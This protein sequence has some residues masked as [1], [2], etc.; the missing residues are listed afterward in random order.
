MNENTNTTVDN[1]N[2]TP[3]AEENKTFSQSDIN[4]IVQERLAKEKS[5][6]DAV[7]VEREREL[8]Q[9]E[10][11][12]STREKLSSK[13]LPVELLDALNLS[14]AESAERSLSIL[15]TY[16]KKQSPLVSISPQNPFLGAPNPAPSSGTSGGIRQAMGLK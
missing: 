12:L 16:I 15:E 8:A 2:A 13:G 7:L 3:R 1:G 5:K 9:R 6:T 14:T 4:R 11:V 10:L